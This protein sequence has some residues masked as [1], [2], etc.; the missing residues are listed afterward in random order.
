VPAR[1]PRRRDNF[2]QPVG[3]KS[4]GV[5][6]PFDDA[7]AERSSGIDEDSGAPVA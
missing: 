5:G 1:H 6:S 4:V 2:G 3:I 7:T